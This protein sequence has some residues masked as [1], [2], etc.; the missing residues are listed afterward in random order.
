MLYSQLFKASPAQ[1]PS[2]QGRFVAPSQQQQPQQPMSYQQAAS[3]QHSQSSQSEHHNSQ[4]MQQQRPTGGHHQPNFPPRM[5]QQQAGN[6]RQQI[7]SKQPVATQ[8]SQNLPS[9]PKAEQSIVTEVDGDPKEK[10][11]ISSAHA[12]GIEKVSSPSLVDSRPLTN[13][14]VSVSLLVPGMYASFV[15]YYSFPF[16]YIFIVLYC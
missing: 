11:T 8:G 12:A 3:Q 9:S 1:D 13:E 16:H 15:L 2:N 10:E 5:L 7:A 4:Y 6:P 14:A